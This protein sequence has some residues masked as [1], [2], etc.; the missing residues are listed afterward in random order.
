[1]REGERSGNEAS[2]PSES[3]DNLGNEGEQPS[4][5]GNDSLN[6]EGLVPRKGGADET[7]NEGATGGGSD[8]DPDDKGEDRGKESGSSTSQP[9][10]DGGNTSG[11]D[12][13]R[14]SD[15]NTVLS[16]KK[17]DRS[18]VSENSTIGASNSNDL[19]RDGREGVRDNGGTV[20]R[21]GRDSLANSN[22]G[23]RVGTSSGDDIKVDGSVCGERAGK[24]RGVCPTSE[25]GHRLVHTLHHGGHYVVD[26]FG[27]FDYINTEIETSI[28]VNPSSSGERLGFETPRN[29][30]PVEA[31]P[32]DDDDERLYWVGDSTPSDESLGG[33]RSASRLVGAE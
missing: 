25:D 31:S 13:R 33:G 22:P 29:G 18:R 12:E 2:Q 10:R 28:E 27:G 32:S 4:E 24:V 8:P 11:P 26:R 16:D 3:G 21:G 20:V 9:S 15:S 7:F 23:G 5:S 6:D 17:R 1:M 19:N 30:P 14:N